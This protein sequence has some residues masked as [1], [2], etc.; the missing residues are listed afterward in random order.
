MNKQHIQLSQ[1]DYD[2]LTNLLAKGQLPARV[3]KRATALLELHQGKTLTAV[4]CTLHVPYLTVSRW[5]DSYLDNA[6]AFLQDKQRS[7]RPPLIDGSQ[8]AKVTALACSTPP[9]GH[10]RW[11]L[12]LLADKVV[13]LGYCQHLSHT[14]TRQILKKTNFNRI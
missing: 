14:K 1:N 6:L 7:G 4:A 11:T 9:Q 3:F 12:R 10:A 2:F 13:E 5:R 8:R